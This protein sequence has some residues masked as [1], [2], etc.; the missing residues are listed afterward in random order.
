M[1]SAPRC[2]PRCSLTITSR[3]S[4]LLLA[5][6][7]AACGDTGGPRFRGTDI[8]GADYGRTPIDYR[9]GEFDHQMHLDTAVAPLIPSS[10]EI[11]A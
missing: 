10:S 3:C 8:T 5:F 7:L 6:L 11:T 1:A 4:A 2:L 9:L